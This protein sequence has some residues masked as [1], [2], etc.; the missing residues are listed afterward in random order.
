[1]LPISFQTTDGSFKGFGTT[2][3]AQQFAHFA[4]QGVNIFRIRKPIALSIASATRLN[5]FI[6]SFR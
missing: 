3:P 6:R 5:H 4:S 2:P 1:M